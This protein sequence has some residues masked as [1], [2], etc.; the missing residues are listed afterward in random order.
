MKLR[1]DDPAKFRRFASAYDHIVRAT[2]EVMD[3]QNL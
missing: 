2:L 3:E 1:L